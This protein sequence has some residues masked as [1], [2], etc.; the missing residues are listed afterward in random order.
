[1][2]TDL[3]FQTSPF[4]ISGIGTY[5]TGMTRGHCGQRSVFDRRIVPQF[6]AG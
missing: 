4:E 1:M 3:L 6:A 5:N 2:S